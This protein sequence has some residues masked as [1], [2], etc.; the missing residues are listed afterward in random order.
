MIAEYRDVGRRK[1]VDQR[2]HQKQARHDARDAR[3]IE[4]AHVDR[5][6]GTPPAQR[7]GRD[8]V[9]RDDEKHGDAIVAVPGRRMNSSPAEYVPDGCIAQYVSDI[10]V[11]QQD[12]QDRHAAKRIDPRIAPAGAHGVCPGVTP[13]ANV[14]AS[15][16]A[17]RERTVPSAE[18]TTS[19]AWV[20]PQRGSGRH[21]VHRRQLIFIFQTV[22]H[23]SR[24]E[25]YSSRFWA[26]L[27]SLV[28]Q[29]QRKR[30]GHRDR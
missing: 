14:G 25:Q 5:A 18:A 29:S 15:R 24:E 2:Q 4:R 20:R 8:Q 10:E 30:R 9:A 19:R 3:H 12:K 28:A 13:S 11:M 6:E 16:N 27:C 23:L 7:V 21:F 26:S 17:S 1:S 22:S